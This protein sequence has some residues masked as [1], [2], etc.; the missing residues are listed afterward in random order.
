MRRNELDETNDRG[1]LCDHQPYHP[2][3]DLGFRIRD[4][5]PQLLQIGLVGKA[6]LV[7]IGL[8]SE[9]QLVQIDLCGNLRKIEFTALV[10]DLG[11]R[12]G[13]RLGG[14]RFPKPPGARKVSDVPTIAR[15]LMSPQPAACSAP[16]RRKRAPICAVDRK[17]ACHRD[18]I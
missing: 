14:A 12:I 15:T 2:F 6:Q 3:Q 7:Q 1:G 8:C 11:N 10:Q 9:A 4:L 5:D 17:L 18:K 16:S 13:Y